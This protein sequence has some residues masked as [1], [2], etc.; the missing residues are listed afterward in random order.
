M[1]FSKFTLYSKEWQLISGFAKALCFPGRLEI[2]YQLQKEGPIT[3]Q[4]L[5]KGHPI[6]METISG[7][8][9]IL[10]EAHLVIAEER[11]PYTFYRIHEK[12]MKKAKEALAG[13]F[14]YFLEDVT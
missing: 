12:N 13:F 10:R 2:L 11:Y 9:K 3:V 4:Q 6:C 14:N 5:A 8:L 7:H 1:A